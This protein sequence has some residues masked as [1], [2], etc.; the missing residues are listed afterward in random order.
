MPDGRLAN[1]PLYR[2]VLLDT[3]L[4]A[5]APYDVQLA[6]VEHF[7][8]VL[9][10]GSRRL[11]DVHL[12]RRIIQFARAAPFVPV[13]LLTDTVKTALEHYFRP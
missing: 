12:V 8:R 5:H 4:W 13:E 1:I 7:R 6:Y 3:S 2:T 9:P 11:R 10:L